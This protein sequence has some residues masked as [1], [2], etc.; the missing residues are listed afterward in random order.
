MRWFLVLGLFFLVGCATA[1]TPISSA[2]TATALPVAATPPATATV[3]ALPRPAPTLFFA[4]TITTNLIIQ[5]DQLSQTVV[6]SNTMD[7]LAVRDDGTQIAIQ[8]HDADITILNLADHT[9][10]PINSRCDSM[11]WTLDGQSLICARHGN[12]YTIQ[13][14]GMSDTLTTV[15][16]GLNTYGEFVWR[17]QSA[18]LWFSLDGGTTP[19]ICTISS[20]T[21]ALL[22]IGNGQ[23]PRW[24]PNGQ[25]LAYRLG[26][27]VTVQSADASQQYSL[28]GVRVDNL[29]WRDDAHLLL[30]SNTRIMQYSLADHQLTPLTLGAA[31][32]RLVAVGHPIH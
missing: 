22:C 1:P 13:D 11:V 14:N 7:F 3:N 5:Q 30:I 8:P 29:L 25:W 9:L 4:D 16:T 12:I 15:A 18:Q 6:L 27:R 32:W 23:Q 26:D 21:A 31:T 20:S 2:P 17:T 10:Q 28:T 24:S 19:Q